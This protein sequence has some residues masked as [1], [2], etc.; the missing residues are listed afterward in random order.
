[1]KTIRYII[2]QPGEGCSFCKNTNPKRL[3]IGVTGKS[4]CD[5]CLPQIRKKMGLQVATPELDELM[6]DA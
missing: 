4:M 2:S 3:F 5:T 1:M 6:K